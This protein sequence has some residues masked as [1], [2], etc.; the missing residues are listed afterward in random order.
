MIEIFDENDA[1]K[2]EASALI[3][4]GESLMPFF[5]SKDYEKHIYMMGG[6]IYLK[7]ETITAVL[8]PEEFEQFRKT[9]EEKYTE[10]G[11]LTRREITQ[12]LKAIYAG[13]PTPSKEDETFEEFNE[14]GKKVAQDL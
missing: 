5:L 7:G 2:I 1:K 6:W 10:D 8:T 12:L 14:E 13:E 3:S 9:A 4:K 11:K